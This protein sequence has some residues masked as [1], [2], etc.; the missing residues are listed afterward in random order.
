MQTQT[1]SGDL[2]GE[3]DTNK[4]AH[5]GHNDNCIVVVQ[6]DRSLK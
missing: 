3:V 1:D 6:W 4:S 2:L 5:M